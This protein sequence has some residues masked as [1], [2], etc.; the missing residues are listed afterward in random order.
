MA[1]ICL[2]IPQ[3]LQHGGAVCFYSRA[4]IVRRPRYTWAT[5]S[6]PRRLLATLAR[7]RC[8]RGAQTLYAVTCSLLSSAAC[9]YS[10]HSA[11][12]TPSRLPLKRS[13]RDPE[14]HLGLNA[15]LFRECS[16]LRYDVLL[17]SHRSARRRQ[18]H[19]ATSL[20]GGLEPAAG[21]IEFH[22]IF[23]WAHC[24]FAACER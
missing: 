14:H 16:G 18:L 20:V 15:R 19:P 7:S 11:D 22:D 12:V 5:P 17:V 10:L 2:R 23:L 3:T 6:M 24:L 9:A 8:P 4:H 1:A 13:H 21:M